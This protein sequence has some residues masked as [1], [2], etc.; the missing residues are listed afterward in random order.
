MDEQ[1]L[2]TPWSKYMANWSPKGPKGRLFIEGLYK[3]IPW[4]KVH[5]PL[6]PR[7]CRSDSLRKSNGLFVPSKLVGFENKPFC[8]FLGGGILAIFQRLRCVSIVYLGANLSSIIKVKQP[9]APTKTVKLE[10]AEEAWLV[11]TLLYP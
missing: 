5:F 9:K 1:I 3:P 4:K 10:F 6:F 2:G 11:L 7:L 8:F